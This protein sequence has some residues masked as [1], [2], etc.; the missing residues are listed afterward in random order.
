MPR[1]YELAW[2]EGWLEWGSSGY[3][4]LLNS[5]KQ[6][7]CFARTEGTPK[8][9]FW[10]WCRMRRTGIPLFLSM[11][12]ALVLEQNC[13]FVKQISETAWPWEPSEDR[14]CPGE[15]TWSEHRGHGLRCDFMPKLLSSRNMQLPY[16]WFKWGRVFDPFPWPHRSQITTRKT[17]SKAA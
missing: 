12:R 16:K 8:P 4:E 17:E 7:I 1:L 6:R 15:R 2:G 14:T 13:S 11:Q 10:E 5:V 9:P 3:F